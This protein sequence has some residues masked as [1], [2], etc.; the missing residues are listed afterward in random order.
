MKTAITFG[1]VPG[2]IFGLGTERHGEYM[3]QCREGEVSN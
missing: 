1:M 3:A 2:V